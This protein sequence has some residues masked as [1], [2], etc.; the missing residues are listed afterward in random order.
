MKIPLLLLHGALGCKEQLL[1]L[2]KILSEKWEILTLDFEGHGNLKSN[3]DFSMDLFTQNVMDFLEQLGISNINIFGYSMGGYVAFNL[4]KKHPFL[5]NKIITLG[6]KFE[7]TPSFAE[8]EVKMLNPEKIQVKIPSFAGR[9]E[10]LHGE[11]WKGVVFKTAL[12][13]PD[14]G[15]TPNLKEKNFRSISNKSLICLGELDK[16]ATIEESQNVASWL[17]NGNF[18]LISNF[19][20]P[21]E[22]ISFEK[23]ALIINKH[24]N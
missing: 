24:L 16:M 3:K 23:L 5:V 17:P 6:T 15:N 1:P 10:Q 13:M 22:A 2:Q 20:H 14:L 11:N 12:M 19:K 4:A 8:K 21:L 7:W 9:L 18:Q